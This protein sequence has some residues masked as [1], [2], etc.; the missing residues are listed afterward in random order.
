MITKN[1]QSTFLV[2]PKLT[3]GHMRT[4]TQMQLVPYMTIYHQESMKTICLS[5]EKR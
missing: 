2:T 4:M 5:R 1:N 3:E